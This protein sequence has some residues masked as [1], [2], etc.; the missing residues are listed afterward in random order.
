MTDTPVET[1]AE[2]QAEGQFYCPGCGAR[3]NAPGVCAAD[4][5]P[6]EL[7]PVDAPLITEAAAGDTPSETPAEG[8]SAE[9]PAQQP[10]AGTAAEPSAEQTIASHRDVVTAALAEFEQAVA[11]FKA[12][13]GI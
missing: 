9:L 13:V 6:I 11:A 12:K 1:S 7:Q 10:A 8:A 4:H 5:E 3:Y 2:P